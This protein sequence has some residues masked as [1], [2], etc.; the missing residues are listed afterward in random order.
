MSKVDLIQA[1]LQTLSLVERRQ[2]RDWLDDMV[3]DDLEFTDDFEAKIRAS[4][5]D[6][7]AGHPSR[8]R[9]TWPA[10]AVV[11]ASLGAGGPAVAAAGASAGRV[12]CVRG[13]DQR[14]LSLPGARLGESLGP[15]ERVARPT[16]WSWVASPA[17]VCGRLRGDFDLDGSLRLP[18]L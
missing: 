1:E 5:T 7:A 8:T 16:A 17:T 12:G 18:G 15:I 3:E 14:S 13:R 6:M 4:E 11:P 9:G 2:V 10:E